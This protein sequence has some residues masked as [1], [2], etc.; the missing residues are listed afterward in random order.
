MNNRRSNLV[1]DH[2]LVVITESDKIKMRT[3]SSIKLYKLYLSLYIKIYMIIYLKIIYE[4]F[5]LW[6]EILSVIIFINNNYEF[7]NVGW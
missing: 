4:Y 3:F 5:T 7:N 2:T 1:L 6:D